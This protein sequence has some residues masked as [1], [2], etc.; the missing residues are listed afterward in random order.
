MALADRIKLI[1]REPLAHFL[2][3]GAFIFA[4]NA[5][6]DLPADPTS[7]TI[8]IDETQVQQ[9]TANFAKSWQRPPTRQ[10]VDGLIRDY[11]REE[12]YYREALRLGLD[13]DDLV[14]RRR[15]RA[16]MEFLA[17]SEAESATP[18]DATL[19][20]LMDANP[21]RYS[22]D[23]A[24]S[25][26]QVYIAGNDANVSRRRALEVQRK[27][28]AGGKP[29]G[30]GDALSVP[31]SMESAGYSEIARAF[32]D[33]FADALR[34]LPEGKWTGPVESGF[35][36]H[37]VRKRTSAKPVAAKLSAVRQKVENDW[38]EATMEAREAKSY[39]ALLDGYTIRIAAPK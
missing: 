27:L 13:Q 26:D 38:R 9:L 2:I 21:A 36:V 12:I 37:V 6:R 22:S 23:A 4:L 29:D 33:G 5:M 7:R 18:D 25:F 3:A 15:L 30:L 11:I 8:T 35:G 14:I 1:L 28:T 19:Q 24:Y 10:E 34:T 31:A 39:Q 20:A 32:G 17:R 16:K